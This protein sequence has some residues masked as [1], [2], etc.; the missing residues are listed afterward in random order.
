MTLFFL[1]HYLCAALQNL[2][3]KSCLVFVCGQFLRRAA[4][5]MVTV[6]FL[7]LELYV[8]AVV[9][10]FSVRLT[11]CGVGLLVALVRVFGC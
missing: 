8:F 10:I 7:H 1:W 2:P 3:V 4:H 6:L 9:F 5:P 11:C